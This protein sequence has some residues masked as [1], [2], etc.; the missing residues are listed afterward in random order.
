MPSVQ[1]EALA[2]SKRGAAES[3]FGRL[4]SVPA[5]LEAADA[6]S[7]CFL[8]QCQSVETTDEPE[9]K[10][11][12]RK[13]RRFNAETIFSLP[14]VAAWHYPVQRLAL[15]ARAC[16]YGEKL[17]WS[18]P[19]PSGHLFKPGEVELSFTH[20]DGG[21]MA[22]G[23]ALTGF[24]LAGADRVWKPATARIAGDKVVVSSSEVKQPVAARYAWHADPKANLCN[25]AGLPASPFR[26]DNW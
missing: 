9:R 4:P 18:G 20:T 3:P 2:E 16:V 6:Y 25:G 26:T 11:E 24:E 23:G 1:N 12:D 13:S 15:R 14:S 21:L 22:K 17:P 5:F 19:L 8:G 10:K 7:T